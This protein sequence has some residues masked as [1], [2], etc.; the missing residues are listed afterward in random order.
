MTEPK[1]NILY[2]TIRKVWRGEE[3]LVITYWLYYTIGS[4]FFA[5]VLPLIFATLGLYEGQTIGVSILVLF[6]SIFSLMYVVFALVATWRS[7]G[8]Y[9]GKAVWSIL[10]RAAVILA[11]LVGVVVVILMSFALLG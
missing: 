8:N 4:V 11:I 2:Q 1:R 9:D 3:R 6:Y 7:A 10:A 5:Q